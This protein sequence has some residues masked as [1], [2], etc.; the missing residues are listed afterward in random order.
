MGTPRD[1]KSPARTGH[2]R[3][4]FTRVHIYCVLRGHEDTHSNRCFSREEKMR[5]GGR[6]Y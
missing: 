4:S 5:R 1:W 2:K 3:R 6:R